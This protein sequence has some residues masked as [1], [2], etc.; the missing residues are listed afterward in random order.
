[1]TASSTLADLLLREADLYDELLRLLEEEERALIA[2]DTRA[3][4]DCLAR[5]E[6]VV[7]TLRLLENSRETLVA[8][9]AGHGRARLAELPGADLG[10]LGRARARLEASLPRV[11][12]MNR[13]I[14]ALLERSLRL[15]DATLELI[16]GTAGLGRQYTAAG[17]LAS[18]G[19]PTID[20][21]A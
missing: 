6:T 4:A 3:V 9:L 12:R 5:S 8:R 13:R 18:V 2:G 14:T 20:G 21:R 11:E 16:R 7:L 1:M 17:T 19:R 10:P 15:F